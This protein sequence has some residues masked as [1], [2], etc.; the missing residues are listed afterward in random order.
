MTTSNRGYT[1]ASAV[2]F[3]LATVI[4]LWRALSGWPVEINHYSVPVAASWG[5]ATLTGLL[6]LWG[7]RS[8]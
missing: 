1:T 4:Q 5:V 3:T 2:V 6:A 7:W 8:R